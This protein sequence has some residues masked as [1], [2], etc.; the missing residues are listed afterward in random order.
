[1]KGRMAEAQPTLIHVP[2]VKDVV[3]TPP[4]L[5]RL[6]VDHFAPWG[7]CLDPC[8]GDGSFYDCLPEQDRDWCEIESG[9]DF[10]AYDGR[11]DWIIS[12]PPYSILMQ[13]IRHSFTVADNV[14]YLLP[15]HRVMGSY[16]FVRDVASYGGI[17]EIFVLG[18]GTSVGFPFGHCLAAVHYRRGYVGRTK[19]TYAND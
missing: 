8:L 9:R 15:L 13:W 4:W 11:A 5:A 10:L 1:M 17:V 14:V 12:N 2:V 6:I 18:T 16:Q 3:Y 19:W 7:K